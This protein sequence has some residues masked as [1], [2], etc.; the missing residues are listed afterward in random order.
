[1]IQENG[2]KHEN[3]SFL[4]IFNALNVLPGLPIMQ[5]H[6]TANL[7]YYKYFTQICSKYLKD[8][9]HTY[10]VLTCNIT[11]FHKK[12]LNY[13]GF[14][15]FPVEQFITLLL[16]TSSISGGKFLN[17]AGSPKLCKNST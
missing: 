2:Q 9:S 15:S 8:L 16:P 1:M 12:E 10:G 13:S 11:E 17:F 7:K 6:S 5:C 4:E 3:V 14:P